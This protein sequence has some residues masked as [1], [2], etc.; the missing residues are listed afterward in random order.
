MHYQKLSWIFA[1]VIFYF[2]KSENVFSQYPAGTITKESDIPAYG[3]PDPLQITGGKIISTKEQWETEQRPCL[4]SLFE[5]NIYGKL[6]DVNIQPVYLIREQNNSALNG[7]AIRKQVRIFLHPS[8]TSVYI[9]LLLYL[10]TKTTGPVP[11][12]LGYNFMGNQSTINDSAVFLCE[13]P[14]Y[15]TIG[16]KNTKAT[17][18]SRGIDSQSWPVLKIIEQGYGLVTA[19]YA[20][21][22][23][24]NAEGY[25]TGIRTSLQEVLNMPVN[26][27][28][29]IGAWSWGLSRIMDYLEQDSSVNAKKVALIGHSRLGKVCLWAG[30][31]DRRFAMVIS[32]ESGE[33]GAALSK[34]IFGETVKNLT[35]QFPYW[36]VPAYKKF[37]VNTDSLPVDQHEL[38]ALIAP[39][40]LYVASASDDLW[41]DP[42]GEF[43]SLLNAERV[44]HLYK[45][46]G[47]NTY[48][49]P[50]VNHPVG[51]EI[52]YHVRKG[53]H[54]ITDYDWDQY[55]LFAKKYL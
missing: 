16:V 5:K 6:P 8:D 11:V 43:L 19:C 9:D 14:V 10:P 31:S 37:A 21:I 48:F 1:F 13:S 52:R 51:E 41:S 53:G 42:K 25:K 28:G 26:D 33:G 7:K 55:L 2:L 46:E 34:R 20:D 36:F 17:D 27:W 3:L 32:N 24:D 40:P 47:L 35:D 50:P 38:L 4:Y 30:A 45:L 12:F 44:Y 49:M 54:G 18:S 22:E 39:R 29:A 23:P 15:G